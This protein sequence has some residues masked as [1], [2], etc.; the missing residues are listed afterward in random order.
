M[1]VLL[2]ADVKGQGKKG[3]IIN[4]SDGYANNFL[5]KKGL[6]VVATADKINSVDIHNKAVEKQKAAER[7]KA[8]EDANRLKGQTVKITSSTGAQGKMYGSITNKEIAEELTKMGFPVDKKQVVLKDPIRQKGNY[9]VTVKMYTEIS[10][11]VNVI[12]E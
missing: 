8:Q 12:V 2:L 5:F 7:Q 1:K 9:T 3:E 10:T 6:G 4:V 11:T